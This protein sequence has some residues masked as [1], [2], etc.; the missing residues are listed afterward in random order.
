MEAAMRGG[1]K[2]A[3]SSGSA[4]ATVNS[5]LLVLKASDAAG[6]ITVYERIERDYGAGFARLVRAAFEKSLQEKQQ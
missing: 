4:N 2:K 6:R 3:G 5:M 1:S